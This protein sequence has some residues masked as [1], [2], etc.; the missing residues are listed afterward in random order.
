[1][2]KNKK[3]QIVFSADNQ[4]DDIALDLVRR[5]FGI[6]GVFISNESIL[7]DF[8]DI[9]DIPGH[10]RRTF[11]SLTA[12]EKKLYKK[13]KEL[14]FF[15]ENRFFVWHPPISDEEWDNI[16]RERQYELT[17]LIKKE[18]GVYLPEIL[19]GET[20]IWIIA[21]LISLQLNEKHIKTTN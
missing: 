21:K 13:E 11:A 16:E 3:F 17:A 18:Y 8:M 1:M 12:E 20:H 7:E 9:D 10:E 5:L 14:P 6:E 19:E 2:K 4:I 15:N